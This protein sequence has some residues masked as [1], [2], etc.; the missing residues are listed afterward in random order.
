MLRWG[1]AST[2]DSTQD[3]LGFYLASTPRPVVQCGK[4]VPSDVRPLKQPVA[5]VVARKDPPEIGPSSFVV[6]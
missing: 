6:C 3:V 4:V 5:A 1:M 2:Q